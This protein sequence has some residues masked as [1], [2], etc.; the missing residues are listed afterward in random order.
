M[1]TPIQFSPYLS[2]LTDS[3]FYFK[4]EDL[5]PQGGGG[6]KGRIVKHILKKA[7]KQAALLFHFCNK[8]MI[9]GRE[10]VFFNPSI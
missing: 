10:K 1:I 9:F 8:T 7:K 3:E 4:R 6:N 5:F 2:A